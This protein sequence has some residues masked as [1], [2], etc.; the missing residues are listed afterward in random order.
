MC[1][2]IPMRVDAIDGYI[3]RCSV[4]GV[5]RDVSL[6]MLEEGSVAVGDSVLVH[7]GYAIQVISDDEA[8]A[9]W[10]VFDEVLSTE[11]ER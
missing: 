3:A 4:R 9:T 7:V 8:R 10:Q 6:F 1:L 11:P 2:A 5:L